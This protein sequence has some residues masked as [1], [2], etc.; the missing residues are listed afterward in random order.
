MTP[1]QDIKDLKARASFFMSNRRKDIDLYRLLADC[2][3]LCERVEMTGQLEG[4]KTRFLQ[5]QKA[6]GRRAY[7]EKNSDVFLIVGRCVFE[8]E[9]NREASWRYIAAMREAHSRQIRP[10]NLVEWL[11]SEGGINVLFKSRPLEA[12]TAKTKT[13][14]LNE[15]IEVPKDGSFTLTLKRDE[16]G[17]FDVVVAPFINRRT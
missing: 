10:E 3:S 2:M 12:R 14:N 5:E 13:L 7:F 17:F 9:I 15:P 1:D 4:L 16:R 11:R 8:P 6:R